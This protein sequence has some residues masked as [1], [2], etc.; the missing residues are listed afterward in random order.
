MASPSVFSQNTTQSTGATDTSHP[1]TFPTHAAGDML[2]VDAIFDGN[3][4]VTIGSGSGWAT[5]WNVKNTTG[6]TTPTS[7]GL[8]KPAGGSSETLTL[9]SDVG[10]ASLIAVRVVRGSGGTLNVFAPTPTS[11]S[12]TNGTGPAISPGAGSQDML[13]CL[14][15]GQDGVQHASAG[16]S[17]YGN[18][19]AS[20]NTTAARVDLATCEKASTAS[21]SDTPGAWTAA[22]E[23]WI[24]AGRAV[25]EDAG[26][27][28]VTVDLSVTDAADTLSADA[29]LAIA[30]NL[31]AT[32]AA[33]TLSA[34]AVLPIVANL[35]VTDA[36]DTLSSDADVLVVVDLSATDEADTLDATAVVGDAPVEVDL[37]VTDEADTLAAEADPTVAVSLAVTD[38]S[39]TLA[40][41]STMPVTVDLG[42]TD[43]AD[44]LAATVGAVVGVDLA[45][46]DEADTLEAAATVS[47]EGEIT[48]T[49]DVVDDPDTLE[50]E[51]TLGPV[52]QRSGS[53]GRNWWITTPVDPR[54]VVV[55]VTDDDD[56]LE[57]T[58]TVKWSSARVRKLM[59]QH[60]KQ[61]A[62][63]GRTVQVEIVDEDDTLMSMA[64]VRWPRAQL[65]RSVPLT[66][67]G[68]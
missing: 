26:G 3:P 63:R 43:A 61:L 55:N 5:D 66:R 50:A 53:G 45:V 58:A 48:V 30:V 59:A 24:A 41:A 22:A 9:T 40:A 1:V 6:S 25:W 56:T 35:S 28:P 44:T 47:Q 16:P 38:A 4:N 36:S 52:P 10:E 12:S 37:S 33:D 64:T 60:A 68:T 14:S 18:F 31:S 54:V 39:D 57:A 8:S 21:S 7:V 11:G 13:Y 19:V 67:A 49:L 62:K 51:A 27:S 15:Y 20:V 23:Q 17:G 46:T 32:D 2:L 29:S 34:A 65:V 42:V